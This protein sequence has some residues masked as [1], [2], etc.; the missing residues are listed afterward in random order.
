MPA[1]LK[2]RHC[3]DWRAPIANLQSL[4]VAGFERAHRGWF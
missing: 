2:S 1:L 4:K 3:R